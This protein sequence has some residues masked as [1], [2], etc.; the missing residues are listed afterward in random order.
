MAT[1]R[2]ETM[3]GD[4]AVAVHSTTAHHQQF[5]NRHVIHPLTGRRI[6]IIVDDVLVNPEI[7]TGVVKVQAPTHSYPHSHTDNTHTQ[8]TSCT[9]SCI[10]CNIFRVFT[11][12][13]TLTPPHIQVTP[14][15]DPEDFACGQRQ[16]LPFINILNQDGT[17]NEAAEQYKVGAIGNYHT[18][19]T[20]RTYTRTH[21]PH[22]H[23]P[24]IPQLHNSTRNGNNLRHLHLQKRSTLLTPR[25]YYRYHQYIP[26]VLTHTLQGMDRLEARVAIV[27]W[28]TGAGFFVSKEPHAMRIALCSRSADILEPIIK[29]QW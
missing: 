16:Q 23:T 10:P 15:H 3:L 21:I 12:T 29:P 19:H 22:A 4:T 24:R 11:H 6:P 17:L 28:M 14:A 13:Y 1:T 20:T 26:P 25:T 18:Y 9:Y 27:K 7:G 2:P 8:H 5:H